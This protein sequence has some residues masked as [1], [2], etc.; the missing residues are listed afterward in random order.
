M[1]KILIIIIAIIVLASLMGGAGYYLWK[2]RARFVQFEINPLD[3][4]VFEV[5]NEQ[6]SD[7]QRERGF[8]RFNSAKDKINEQLE[9]GMVIEDESLLSTWLDLAS[10]LMAIGDYDRAVAIW[11]WLTDAQPHSSMASANLGDFYKSVEV[12]NEKSEFYYIMALE[13]DV[14]DFEIYH[15]LYEIYRYNFK[16]SEKA[17]EILRNGAENNPDQISYISELSAYLSVLNR[18]E[19]ASEI[20][21]EYLVNHPEDERLRSRLNR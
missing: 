13:R 1:K 15:G 3:L 2:S 7:Y 14:N 8:A 19:E 16:D 5:Q 17:I 21:N 6:L 12:D 10:V 9:A 4:L 11:V 20:I 18:A